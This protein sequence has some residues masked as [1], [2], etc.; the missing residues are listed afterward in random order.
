LK[1]REVL[2]HKRFQKLT[3]IQRRW[4]EE[5]QKRWEQKQAE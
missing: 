2:G 4:R 1:S 3:E 5:H